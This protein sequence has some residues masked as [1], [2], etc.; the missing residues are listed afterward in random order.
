M[1]R[2]SLSLSACRRVI[3]GSPTEGGGGSFPSL[4]LP[5]VGARGVNEASGRPLLAMRCPHVSSTVSSTCLHSL[6]LR[7]VARTF[8]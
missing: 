2:L 4:P 3:D 5:A 1:F 7:S 8:R 6:Q